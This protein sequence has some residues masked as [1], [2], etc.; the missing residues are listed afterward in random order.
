MIHDLLFR[1]RAVFRRRAMEAELDEELRAHLEHQAEKHMRRGLSREEAERRARFDF[2]DLDQMKDECRSSWGVRLIDDAA[3]EVRAVLRQ[4]RRKPVFATVSALALVLG[5]LANTMMFDGVTSVVE[6]FSPHQQPA[7]PVLA[8]QNSMPPPPPVNKSGARPRPA[9]RK[10][11]SKKLSHARFS[12]RPTESPPERLASAS[13]ERVT[14]EKAA[15][16]CMP[17]AGRFEA[18]KS[19]YYAGS[20]RIHFVLISRTWSHARHEA[21]LEELEM[22]IHSGDLSY[23]VVEVISSNPENPQQESW[24]PL[25]L[26]ARAAMSNSAQRRALA[27]T[28]QSGQCTS[29]SESLSHL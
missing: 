28:E 8:A 19:V 22:T 21:A 25:V 29:A 6:R 10:V 2:G 12:R 1:A 14:I 5:L 9:V 24:R 20:N 16:L 4:A 17:G 27:R 13:G 18:A 7:G 23:T 11:P 15:F 26:N 3:A